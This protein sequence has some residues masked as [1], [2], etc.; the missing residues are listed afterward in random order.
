MDSGHWEITCCCF[1]N[2]KDEESILEAQASHE[3]KELNYKNILLLLLTTSI[4]Y[5]P[6][7]PIF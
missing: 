6:T 4:S 5:L 2:K 1:W 7:V 3:G